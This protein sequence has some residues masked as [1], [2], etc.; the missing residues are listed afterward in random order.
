M[1][2]TRLENSESAGALKARRFHPSRKLAI[3][4]LL[5]ALIA[6]CQITS[7]QT[8]EGASLPCTLSGRVVNALTGQPVAEAEVSAMKLSKG[9]AAEPRVVLTDAAGEFVITG[10]LAGRY[11]IEASRA[12]YPV[13][14][15]RRASKMVV[16]RPNTQADVE[17]DLN[18][19]GVISGHVVDEGALP[20]RGATVRALKYSFRD[21]IRQLEEMASADTNAKGEYR[22]VALQPGQYVIRA[23]APANE[24]TPKRG[25]QPPVSLYYPN[26]GDFLHATPLD[27]SAGQEVAGIDITLARVP[28]F[29]I[30]GA[31]IDS[32]SGSPVQNA[33]LTILSDQG[34]TYYRSTA[35]T[36]DPHGQFDLTEIAPG[37]YVLVAQSTTA[38]P[39]TTL[40]GR[41]AVEV[42]DTDAENVKVLIGPGVN[43]GGRLR[44]EGELSFT[45]LE[46]DLIPREGTTLSGLTPSVK[47]APVAADGT[48]LFHHVPA[49]EYDISFSPLPA[50]FYLAEDEAEEG[51][52][53]GQG[54]SIPELHPLLRSSSASIEGRVTGDGPVADAY[55]VLVP[56]AAR[57]SS[58]PNLRTSVSNRFGRF[59]LRAIVPGDYRIFASDQIEPSA[60]LDPDFLRRCQDCGQLL[61][62]EAGTRASVELQILNP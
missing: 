41:V 56:D 26:A 7:A 42:A 34:N 46:V 17:L 25:T 44:A 38:E 21:G 49:G 51:I 5:V 47:T 40:W 48:F 1:K 13:V 35:A 52:R 27:L 29:H 30:R 28:A 50:G 20:L 19:G 14:Q 12:G 60:F 18:P 22:F 32:R 24:Q 61:H 59:T 55:V 57:S 6:S 54:N 33:E 62:I 3:G 15:S 36:A 10:L 58:G 43:L 45:G 31:V 16:V 37:S 9:D 11:V 53:I 39:E 2:P 4:L 23:C 8:A